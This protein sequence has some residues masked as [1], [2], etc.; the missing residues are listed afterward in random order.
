MCYY[1]TFDFTVTHTGIPMAVFN[2]GV[3]YFA[4]KGV[5]QSFEKARECFLKASDR[6][7]VPAQVN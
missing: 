3:M 7:F 5:G 4:G 2:V 1:N 6:G